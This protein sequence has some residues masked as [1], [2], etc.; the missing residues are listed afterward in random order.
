VNLLQR[1]SEIINALE[2]LSDVRFQYDTWVR[3]VPSPVAQSFNDLIADLYD[4]GD[5]RGLLAPPLKDSGLTSKEHHALQSAVTIIDKLLEDHPSGETDEA[6]L[7]DSRWPQ[8]RIAA[9]RAAKILR[10]S[11]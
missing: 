9:G 4:T 10:E 1:R 5:V 7:H 2:L 11:E 6:I 3:H 8:I